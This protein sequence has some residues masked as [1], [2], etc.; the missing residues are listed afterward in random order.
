MKIFTRTLALSDYIARK[1]EQGQKVG[2]VPTMGALHDGHLQLITTA[3]E[4]TD[5]VVCS[6]FV[7]P[8]QFNDAQD[9]LRYPRPHDE[10]IALLQSI[11]CP[12]LYMPSVMEVYPP[13]LD[14]SIDIEL[15]G[16]D[17]M[18]EGRFRPGHF[19]GMLEVVNRL[20]DIVSADKLYMGQKDYQ[21]QLI[22]S[23][24][25]DSRGGVPV[26]RVLPTVREPDGLAISSRNQR[27]SSSHRE[28]STI[29]YKVLQSIKEGIGHQ[30]LEQLKLT[31]K[32]QIEAHGLKPEYVEIC[33][34]D[35]LATIEDEVP[36]KDYVALVAAWAGDVRLIDNILLTV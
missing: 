28:A 8:S 35:T 15:D 27:L 30:S 3:M 24:L 7:N 10:D 9:L 21:Q 6:I 1:K 33:D 31:A 5:M 23:R 20:L 17:R 2:F 26:L 16:L 34:V 13:G 29:L 12:V 14:T 11:G 32:R 18:L 25:I 22:V 19:D 36:N 4:E